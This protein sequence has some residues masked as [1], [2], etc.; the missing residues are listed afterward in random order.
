MPP[1]LR[2]VN[3]PLLERLSP[4]YAGSMGDDQ[5]D[6]QIIRDEWVRNK[7]RDMSRVGRRQLR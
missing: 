7:A 4:S 3:R 2:A 5:A 1:D 6:A